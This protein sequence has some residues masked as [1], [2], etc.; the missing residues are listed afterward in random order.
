MRKFVASLLLLVIAAAPAS[1]G[2]AGRC[3]RLCRSE[4]VRCWRA[5]YTRVSCRRALRAQCIQSGGAGC[6]FVPPTTTTTVPASSPTTTTTMV[7]PLPATTTTTV[8]SASPTTTTLPPPTTTTTTLPPPP[9]VVD[10]QGVWTFL[11]NVVEDGCSTGSATFLSAATITQYGT[12]LAGYIGQLPA[13]GSADSASWLMTSDT[14]C[15][16][17]CCSKFGMKAADVVGDAAPARLVFTS[18]CGGIQCAS[19]WDGSVVRQSR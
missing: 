9:S 2:V 13:S 15:N 11:G 4:I 14:T 5:G 1:A 12:Y 7:P 17:L 10:A 19:F 3:R 6:E 8:P 16:T 18:I